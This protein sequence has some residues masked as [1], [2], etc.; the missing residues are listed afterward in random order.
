ML[1]QTPELVFKFHCEKWYVINI[2]DL[3]FKYILKYAPWQIRHTTL[4]T[5]GRCSENH[6]IGSEIWTSRKSCCI[7]IHYP[8]TWSRILTLALLLRI[9]KQ[10]SWHIR[11][12]N[13]T[14]FLFENIPPSIQTIVIMKVKNEREK[15]KPEERPPPL[16]SWLKCH[17]LFWEFMRSKAPNTLIQKQWRWKTGLFSPFPSLLLPSLLIASQSEQHPNLQTLFIEIIT[18]ELS[19]F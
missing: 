19:I 16:I 1:T 5:T 13:W 2:T 15:P 18:Y 10:F 3:R 12:Q 7:R 4:Q 8:K 11:V 17:I 14:H 9:C 6:L